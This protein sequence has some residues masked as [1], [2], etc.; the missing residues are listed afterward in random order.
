MIAQL[1]NTSY[2][3]YKKSMEKYLLYTNSYHEIKVKCTGI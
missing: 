1:V 3:S 2:I